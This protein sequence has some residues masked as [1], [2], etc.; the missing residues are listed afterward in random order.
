MPMAQIALILEL[1]SFSRDFRGALL[2]LF[3]EFTFKI[4]IN[5][6]YQNLNLKTEENKKKN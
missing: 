6:S 5:L 4:L 2:L 3:M 1:F